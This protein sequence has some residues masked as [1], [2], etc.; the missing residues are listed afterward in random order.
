[1]DVALNASEVGLECVRLALAASPDAPARRWLTGWGTGSA[2]GLHTWSGTGIDGNPDAFIMLDGNWVGSAAGID[3]DGLSL[4]G[5]HRRTGVRL[6]VHRHRDP[7]VVVS[8]PRQGEA[9]RGRGS[10]ARESTAPAAA[11]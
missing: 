3:R 5:G 2:L 6:L 4:A 11:T 10:T 9:R 8:D 7:G 1:M